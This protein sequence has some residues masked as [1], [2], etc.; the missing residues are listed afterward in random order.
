MKFWQ[1]ADG[2]PICSV[3]EYPIATSTAIKIGQVVKLSAGKIVLATAAEAGT[4]VGVAAENHTGSADA[5]DPR[6]NG[7]VIK[8]IDTPE[9]IYRCK[10]AEVSATGGSATTMTAST[11]G[12]YANDD[13]NGGVI[14]LVEKAA[15]ST[16]TDPVGKVDE[17]TDYSYN[18]T[19]TVSTFTKASGGTPYSGDKYI[20]LPP[21]GLAKGNLS[22][23]I[24]NIVLTTATAFS[25]RY[26]GFDAEAREVL[27]KVQGAKS[28]M[29]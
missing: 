28:L 16:N 1:M 7:T 11:V 9:A 3:R 26:V 23:T 22:S 19:G 6:S 10:V 21:A 2:S 12:A 13:F 20:I 15:G 24:D 25:F 8:V 14:I 17:I 4:V 5:L 27:I 18:S 29:G